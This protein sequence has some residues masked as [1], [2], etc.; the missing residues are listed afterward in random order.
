[1]VFL[2]QLIKTGSV[3]LK[4]IAHHLFPVATMQYATMHSTTNHLFH[5]HCLG[6]CNY[7]TTATMCMTCLPQR[8]PTCH[9][10]CKGVRENALGPNC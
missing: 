4:I 7:S 2:F 10:P 9:I 5:Y 6:S 3:F 8:S 1:M